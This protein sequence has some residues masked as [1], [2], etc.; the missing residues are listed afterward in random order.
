MAN[1]LQLN[2]SK[3]NLESSEDMCSRCVDESV[4]MARPHPSLFTQDLGPR[5]KPLH[6]R[7]HTYHD[8]PV[9][10]FVKGSVCIAALQL[11]TTAPA[12]V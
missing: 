4:S 12:Q 5:D 7:G 9:P 3:L 11:P 1:M 2:T 10:I 8:F 6:G